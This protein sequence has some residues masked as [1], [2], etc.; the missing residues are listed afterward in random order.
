MKSDYIPAPIDVSDIQLPSEL[1]ELAE[2]I[3]KNVHEVWAA[4]RLAE[5]W[6]YGPERNDA[7]RTH[8]GLVPYEE[9]SETEKDY[10]RRTAMETLKLIQ[11][12]G[13]GIKKE[14]VQKGKIPP[15]RIGYLITVSNRDTNKSRVPNTF[16]TPSST[17]ILLYSLVRIS[18]NCSISSFLAMIFFSLS[19]R[20]MTGVES[21]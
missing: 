12:I 4:G 8:P 6:K 5:G 7:L 11:K 17:P 1:C 18:A 20:Y 3:A 16:W 14:G 21:M 10:D 15:C 19:R 2:I 13:F 9:L